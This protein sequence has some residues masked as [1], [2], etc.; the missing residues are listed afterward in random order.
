MSV[1]S[2]NGTKASAVLLFMCCLLCEVVHMCVRCW[3][4]WCSATYRFSMCSC[5]ARARQARAAQRSRSQPPSRT[6]E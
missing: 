2:I 3:R 1:N 5:S 4:S 6:F